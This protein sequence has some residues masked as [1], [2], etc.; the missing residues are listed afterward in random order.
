MSW[1]VLVLILLW[2]LLLYFC[3]PFPI[4]LSWEVT[5]IPNYNFP[6]I[7]IIVFGQNEQ[8]SWSQEK[9]KTAGQRGHNNRKEIQR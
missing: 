3:I 2:F 9:K 8:R 4:H 7:T 6:I 5:P 1:G